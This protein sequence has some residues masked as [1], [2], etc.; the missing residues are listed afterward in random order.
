MSVKTTFLDVCL[1][2]YVGSPFVGY[3]DRSIQPQVSEAMITHLGPRGW[4]PSTA[5]TL[6][7]G[8]AKVVRDNSME[9]N[10]TKLTNGIDPFPTKACAIWPTSDG[11]PNTPC[12]GWNWS[13]MSTVYRKM[14]QPRDESLQDIQHLDELGENDTCN[15]R[16]PVL[17]PRQVPNLMS[18]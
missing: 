10:S 7:K 5:A 8:L 11:A 9:Q 14:Q 2:S 13:E 12:M 17:Q 6:P 3:L 1:D 16:K 18:V 4:I 15:R